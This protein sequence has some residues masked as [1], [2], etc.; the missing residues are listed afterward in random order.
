MPPYDQ[1]AEY[2]DIVFQ[3]LPGEAEFYVGHAVKIGGETLE[4]GCGTGRIAIPMA[5]SGLNVTG[6]D[7][8]PA[9][10]DI[11]RQKCEAVGEMEGN[12]E[13]VEADM[14]DFD[15][16]RQ[17][18]CIAMPYRAFMHLLTPEAQMD[19]LRRVCGHLKDDGLF[20]LNLW[21]ARPTRIAP[22]AS[23][24]RSGLQFAG[25]HEIPGEEGQ[26]AH[27]CTSVYDEF[28]QRISE[29]H[30]LHETDGDGVPVRNACLAME[31]IW[32][33]PR[34]MGCLVRLCGFDPEI[35]LG[36]FDG[37][38]FGPDSTEMIWMLRKA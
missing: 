10:L 21:A 29:E 20:V 19:C 6:L 5:M 38:P 31:R 1:W 22:Y 11:C 9:M 13:L 36:D 7:N 28:D 8:S 2:Y 15:L 25:R 24:Q 17:F 34:E 30:M 3:G 16:S 4:L 14:T 18:D 26:V 33:T 23:G 37:T 35:V 27:Y 32:V 12:L